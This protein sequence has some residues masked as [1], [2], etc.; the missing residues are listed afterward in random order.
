MS[1]IR[2]NP[3]Q[4]RKRRKEAAN[5]IRINI[6]PK[7]KTGASVLNRKWGHKEEENI[8]KIKGASCIAWTITSQNCI[9]E[10]HVQRTKYIPLI[11]PC[12][13]GLK[14]A[15]VRKAAFFFFFSC[16]GMYVSQSYA[17]KNKKIMRNRINTKN[18]LIMSHRFDDMLL[19]YLISCP[20][21]PSTLESV[22]SM[23]SSI[24][25]PQDGY[26]KVISSKW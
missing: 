24:L 23:L 21:A 17:T 2:N 18:I 5:V 7:K 16:M 11:K 25:Q 8:T 4:F 13:I 26:N 15:G 6:K 3:S 1:S 20:C 12:S 10:V 22:S 14:F 19:K 9:T